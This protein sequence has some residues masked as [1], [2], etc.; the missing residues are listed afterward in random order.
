MRLKIL[1]SL[2]D[3]DGL[4]ER[5]K[6]EKAGKVLRKHKKERWR[7]TQSQCKLRNFFSV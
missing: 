5:T 1:E 3:Q 2:S 4:E 6:L 7:E